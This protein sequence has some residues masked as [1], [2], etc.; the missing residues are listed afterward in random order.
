MFWKYLEEIYRITP[1]SNGLDPALLPEIAERLELDTDAF[2]ICLEEGRFKE[3]IDHQKLGG[4]KLGV[5]QTP[6][7]IIWDKKTSEK[8]LISGANSRFEEVKALVEYHLE[9]PE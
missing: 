7:V 6:S 1:S 3:A 4:A 8:K 5:Y 9:Q 2:L